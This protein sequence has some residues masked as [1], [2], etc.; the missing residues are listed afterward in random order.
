MINT[1]YVLLSTIFDLKYTG[2]NQYYGS[3]DFPH[4][5]EL[6][7]ILGNTVEETAL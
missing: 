7:W 3:T 1:S 6:A 5:G 4:Y 2:L